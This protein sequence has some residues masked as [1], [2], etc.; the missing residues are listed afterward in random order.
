MKSRN[1]K[2]VAGISLCVGE[3]F[4]CVRRSAR[5]EGNSV[6]WLPSVARSADGLAACKVTSDG[7]MMLLMP[8][9]S[10]LRCMHVMLASAVSF[11]L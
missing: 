5:T 2:N 4:I 7:P 6:P 8:S 9:V 10:A 11:G 3:V 1:K